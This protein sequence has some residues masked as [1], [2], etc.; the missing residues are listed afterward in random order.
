[1]QQNAQADEKSLTGQ[2]E[3]MREKLLMT[4]GCKDYVARHDDGLRAFGS[5]SFHG[6]PA[7][8]AYVLGGRVG[9][10]A[11]HFRS[12]R[13]K[14]LPSPYPLTGTLGFRGPRNLGVLQ[15]S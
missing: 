2:A 1:M 11:P 6:C 4:S 7:I 13:M 14:G 5:I 15:P 9:M 8:V 10:S 3:L 12:Q